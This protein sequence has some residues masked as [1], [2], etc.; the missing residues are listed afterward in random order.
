MPLAQRV[1]TVD[2][3]TSV[4]VNIENFFMTMFFSLQED[5]HFFLLKFLVDNLFK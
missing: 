2:Q 5:T 4:S 3:Q 1:F